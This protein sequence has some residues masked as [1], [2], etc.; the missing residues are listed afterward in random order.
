MDLD[1]D[2]TWSLWARSEQDINNDTILGNRYAPDGSEYV[3][4]EFIKFTTIQ[5]EFHTSGLPQNIDYDDLVIGEWNHHVAVKDGADLSYYRN[6]VLV[7]S[8][9]I[10]EAPLNQLPL[11]FGGFGLENWQGFLSDVRLWERAIS[12]NEALTLYNDK[13]LGSVEVIEITDITLSGN[14]D[15]ALTWTSRT[16][17]TYI[18]ESSSDLGATF[19]DE[20]DDS[21][22]ATGDTTTY[23][24]P[25][26]AFPNASTKDKLFFRVRKPTP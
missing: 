24:L 15:I 17:T 2:F 23:N 5:F 6:G 16:G 25:G 18:L 12:A 14:N 8:I 9:V 20:I 13:I 3:P 4:R 1:N 7:S 21:V 19:W 26:A 11:Y 22:V 10:T